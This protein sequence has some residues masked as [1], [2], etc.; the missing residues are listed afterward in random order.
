MIY[1]H[2]CEINVYVAVNL[3]GILLLQFVMIVG[4][5]NTLNQKNAVM[6]VKIQNPTHLAIT[7]SALSVAVSGRDGKVGAWKGWEARAAK[8]KIT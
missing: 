1:V 7:V 4:K 6:R 5:K 8:E 3:W 2:V